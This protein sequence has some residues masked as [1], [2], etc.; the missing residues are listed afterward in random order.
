V[1]VAQL[2]TLVAVLALNLVVLGV[3]AVVIVHRGVH[4]ILRDLDEFWEQR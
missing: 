1:T 2:W 3:G 4:G